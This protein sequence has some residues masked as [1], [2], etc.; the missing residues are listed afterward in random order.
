MQK[1]LHG[2]DYDG[3]FNNIE[4]SFLVKTDPADPEK[5]EKIFRTKLRTLAP[6][7]LNIEE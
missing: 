3:L 1:H 4:V 7:G 6:I 2:K 5:R